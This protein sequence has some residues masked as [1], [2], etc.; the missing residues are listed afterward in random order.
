MFDIQPAICSVEA[1]L[2]VLQ[3]EPLLGFELG[4][5]V[6]PRGG[7]HDREE[8]VRDVTSRLEIAHAKS[9]RGHEHE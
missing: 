7:H 2:A 8:F 5:N 9:K 4:K 3:L 1:A 6:I